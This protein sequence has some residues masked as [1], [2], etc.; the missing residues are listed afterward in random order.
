MLAAFGFLTPFGPARA[1][2]PR[3]LRWFPLVGA[4]VGVAI[5]LMWWASSKGWHGHLVPAA[6]AVATDLA[7]TGMLHVDGLVDSADGLLPHLSRSR[8][9]EVMSEPAIGAFGLAAA[10]AVLLLRFAAF[11]ALRPDIAL[12]VGIWCV[13][14]SLMVAAMLVLPYA[15]TTGGLA[16]AFLGGGRVG[17]A[18]A[19]STGVVAGAFVAVWAGGPPAAA[20]LGVGAIAAAAILWL[21]CRRLGGFTGDVL[22]AA[23][24]VSETAAL[25]VSG[26]RW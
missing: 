7:S 1:P 10:V 18:L 2:S 20:G 3:A 25:L 24:V 17:T 13:S 12:V 16:T 14:R 22:G 6:V 23:V 11:D 15:R 4:V 19:A 26:A 8:R 9:L 5:G 21:A